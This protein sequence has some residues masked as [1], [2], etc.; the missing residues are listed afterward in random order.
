MIDRELRAH[1][2][3][4]FMTFD[5]FT[6][7]ERRALGPLVDDPAYAGVLH[8]RDGYHLRMKAVDGPTAELFKKLAEPRPL[9]SDVRNRLGDQAREHIV[10]LV[11]SEVLQV[12]YDTF[13][14]GPDAREL[15][16]LD[17]HAEESHGSLGRLSLA[18]V[19]HASQLEIDDPLRLAAQLYFY[20]RAPVTPRWH[21]R[22][23]DSSAV[24]GF[25]GLR[26]AA[27]NAWRC[28]AD[29]SSRDAWL[30]W[31]DRAERGPVRPLPYKLYVSPTVAAL[32]DAMVEVLS[33]FADEG[34]R[35]FK[36][37]ADAPGLAR[38]DKLVAYFPAFAP[39]ERT[40]C[41]LAPRLL[42][43]PVHGVPFTAELSEDGMLS[44]GLDPPDSPDS[45]WSERASWRSW[46]AL[47]LA[48]GIIDARASR[49][50]AEPWRHALERLRAAGID[51]ATWTPTD[52]YRER[53][54][55]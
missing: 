52:R 48:A 53:P 17:R 21:R 5:A 49:I 6:D 51:T 50:P 38:P 31:A 13:V 9:P 24:Q 18:A 45:D 33:V 44:W 32:P 34:V 12:R 11:L 23:A 54:W 7:D 29:S 27:T 47:R 30:H 35:H 41:R 19:R 37:G 42:G 39:L 16:V 28:S 55:S 15:V 3:Y 1:P 36:V 43:V 4:R 46:I 25:L 26:G 20:G 2:G 10:E 22:L 14:S 8:P 40:A